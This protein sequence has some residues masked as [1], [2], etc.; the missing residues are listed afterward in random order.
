MVL[1]REMLISMHHGIKA[2]LKVLGGMCIPHKHL[3]R[4]RVMRVSWLV[5]QDLI[6]AMCWAACIAQYSVN[7]FF[8]GF[9]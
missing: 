2:D 5:A 1:L 4:L 6:L 9:Y 8:S 3:Q 7:L